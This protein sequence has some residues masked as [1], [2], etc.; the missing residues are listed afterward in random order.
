MQTVTA[1]RGAM[2]QSLR[3]LRQTMTSVAP[4][5]LPVSMA[6]PNMTPQ[7]V[8]AITAHQKAVATMCESAGFAE[9]VATFL[10]VGATTDQ[11]A[12]R[13][14]EAQAICA[15][16]ARCGLEDMGPTLVSSGATLADAREILTATMAA[17]VDNTARHRTA[18][19]LVQQA[20]IIDAGAI[21]ARLNA[22]ASLK[23]DNGVIDA[24]SYYDRLRQQQR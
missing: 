23:L 14:E 9:M 13:L 7:Q 12:E 18:P 1:P 21:Y 2:L 3:N 24:G 5:M 10:R 4:P 8:A 11:V 20:H 15:E 17:R 16:T 6:A 19:A 22:S